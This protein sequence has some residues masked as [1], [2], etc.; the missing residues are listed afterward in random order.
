MDPR[1]PTQILPQRGRV[2][3]GYNLMAVLAAGTWLALV[4]VVSAVF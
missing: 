2:A 1:A 3:N 4:W